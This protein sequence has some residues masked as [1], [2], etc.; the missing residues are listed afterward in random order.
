M[1]VLG[2]IAA[3]FGVKGWLK[4]QP[5]GDDPKL[6]EVMP[7]WWL[8]PEPKTPDGQW[9]RY[10]LRGCQPHSKGLI[11]CLE[12]IDDRSTA[13][14]FSGW[15]VA[16]PCESLPSTEENEYYWGDLIGMAVHDETGELLGEVENLLS[17]GAHDVLQVRDGDTERLIPF[18]AAYVLDVDTKTRSIRTAWQKDW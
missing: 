13:E 16:A 14:P 1:I 10:A 3:P 5:F 6:W 7:H 12:G 11:A 18:V 8:A 2:R 15:Y 9:V 17:T 4:I